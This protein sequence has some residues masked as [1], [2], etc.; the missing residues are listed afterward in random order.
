MLILLIQVDEVVSERALDFFRLI[1]TK[2]SRVI[3]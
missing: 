1:K 2:R 3:E